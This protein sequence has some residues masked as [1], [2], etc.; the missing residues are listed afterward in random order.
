MLKKAVET[1]RPEPGKIWDMEEVESK[2]IL[3]CGKCEKQQKLMKLAANSLIKANAE[4]KSSIHQFLF[5]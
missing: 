1:L 4:L 5:Y 2:L 3:I